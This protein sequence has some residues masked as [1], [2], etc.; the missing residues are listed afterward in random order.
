MDQMS[1]NHF[2]NK[3]S[4]ASPDMTKFSQKKVNQMK[5]FAIEQVQ[6]P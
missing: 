5:S 6:Q 3:F 4:L 1:R 2:Y